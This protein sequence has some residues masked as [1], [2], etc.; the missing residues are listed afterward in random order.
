ME[1]QQQQQQQQQK[2]QQQQQQQHQ[3]IKTF[4]VNLIKYV[5]IHLSISPTIL[6]KTV[7][8]VTLIVMFYVK[9]CVLLDMLPE[10]ISCKYKNLFQSVGKQFWAKSWE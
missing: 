9:L 10:Y 5:C 1:Q 2:Q 6:S 8:C 4:L 3:F 7:M